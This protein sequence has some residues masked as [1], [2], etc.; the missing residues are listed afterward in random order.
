MRPKAR[1]AGAMY[2]ATRTGAT[3]LLE[4]VRARI[5]SSGPLSF[6]EFMGLCLYHE[7]NGYYSDPERHRVGRQ[8]DFVT[9]VSVGALFGTLLAHRL[10]DAWHRA[11]RPGEMMVL[12]PGPEGGHLACDLLA[13]AQDLDPDFRS[14]LHYRA[15]EQNPRKHEILRT[16]LSGSGAP[17]PRVVTSPAQ[18]RAP[19]GVV[20]A[21][22]VLD[23]LPVRLVRFHR[24]TWLE[25]RVTLNGDALAWT[26]TPPAHPELQEALEALPGP[27]P[28]D[29]QTEI[30]LGY[31]PF[32][33]SLAE[34][35]DRAL[36]LFIDDGFS[37]SDYYLPGRSRGTL[38]TY[39]GQQAG[40][41]PL[42]APGT[43]DLSAHVEFTRLRDAGLA[44]GLVPHGFTRQ[45]AYLTALATPLL[46]THERPSHDTTI[47]GAPKGWTLPIRDVLIY[48][49][50]KFLCPCAGPIS[51]MPGTGSNPAYRRVDVETDTGKVTGL[52]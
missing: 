34:V 2:P 18:C 8:G 22:E 37:R 16:T 5:E 39:R 12:E 20:L 14:A 13:A 43:Q 48:S 50:A 6:E 15:C 42:L 35:F 41:D 38:R 3:P 28:E 51:L 49:G 33:R 27:F 40:D 11:G 29:Y 36:V 23:A 45:E 4:I 52:F 46:Q 32:L 47:K 24:G 7:D 31:P 26:E 44:A 1:T 10:H 21:N 9:S 19:C 17:S 30:C 25:R